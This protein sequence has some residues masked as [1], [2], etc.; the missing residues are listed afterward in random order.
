M[1][2]PRKFAGELAEAVRAE[3]GQDVVVTVISARAAW[4][5][6]AGKPVGL[7]LIIEV[8]KDAGGLQ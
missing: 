2:I 1:P 8:P 4:A 3:M 5:E 7:P 6:E